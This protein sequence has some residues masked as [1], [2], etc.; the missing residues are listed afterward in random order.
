MPSTAANSSVAQSTPAAR[1]PE[2]WVRS[3]PK[4]KMTKVV[5][6]N[7]AI[8]GSDCSVR[9]SERRSLARIAAKA[10]REG[11][12][13]PPRAGEAGL[14]SRDR[15]PRTHAPL[16]AMPSSSARSASGSAALGVVG[17]DDAGV[18]A[19]G[20]DQ[21]AGQLA[22]L[23]VEVGV[24]LVEQQQLRLV[25][26]AA[27]DRQ[28]LAH[29]GRELGD[30]LVGAALHPGGGEQRRDPRLGG[31]AGDPVQPGVEA[32]VLAAAEVAV[33][34]RLVA[35]VADPP[36]QLPGLARQRAAEHDGLAAARA[37]QRRQDPQQRRLAGAV[38]PEHD[39]RLAGGD[40]QPDA[41][42]RRAFA[43]VAAQP[44]EPDRRR[45]GLGRRFLLLRGHR[46]GL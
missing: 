2:S 30:A 17:D 28:P 12:T 43:V 4:R 14:A 46:G 33:E 40:G 23:G 10:A 39:Q 31:R 37:Q 9:S 8:A 41:V 15:P 34:Q 19:A 21:A 20:P 16:A 18:A 11:V 45:G 1:L 36:A 38:G 44:G 27:A 13:G 7:S 32:Q 22:P 29:P 35:E 5:T 24:G 6:E 26:D 25:Q 42:Q 3:R